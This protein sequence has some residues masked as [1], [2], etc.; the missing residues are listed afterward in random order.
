[1]GLSLEDG[2]AAVLYQSCAGVGSAIRAR[3]PD[4]MS[5]PLPDFWLIIR[6][7][8]LVKQARRL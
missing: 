7:W 3:D 6:R 8:P 1:M 5:Q 4:H 2:N